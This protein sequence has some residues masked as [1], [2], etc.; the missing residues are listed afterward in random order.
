MN[1]FDP[2]SNEAMHAIDAIDAILQLVPRK[3]EWE[4]VLKQAE[5]RATNRPIGTKFIPIGSPEDVVI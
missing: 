4:F 5:E 1:P 3:E 2:V